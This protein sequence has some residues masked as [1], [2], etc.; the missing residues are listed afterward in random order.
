MQS[1]LILSEILWFLSH[2][3]DTQPLWAE[4]SSP[5]GENC[6]LFQHL[7]DMCASIKMIQ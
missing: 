2:P 5:A 3:R 6:S 1:G 4:C 7:Y